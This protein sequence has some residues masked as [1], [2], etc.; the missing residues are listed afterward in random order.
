MMD[1]GDVSI[2]SATPNAPLWTYVMGSRSEAGTKLLAGLD[3]VA[4]ASPSAPEPVP[5]AALLLAPV[6]PQRQV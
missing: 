6:K 4:S 5:T 3:R 1:G 2:A